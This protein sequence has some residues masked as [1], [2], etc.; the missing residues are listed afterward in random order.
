AMGTGSVVRG[1]HSIAMGAGNTVGK[2][3]GTGA[4][5]TLD[6]NYSAAVGNGNTIEQD[7]T[8]VLG[9]DV[10]TTQANSVVLGNASTDRAATAESGATI[11]AINGSPITYGGFAGVGDPDNGVVSV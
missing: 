9:N 5:A 11:T 8:F 3:N 1:D 7:N 2:A 4:T 6:G 10:T